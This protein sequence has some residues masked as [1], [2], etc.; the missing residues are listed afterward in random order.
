[1]KRSLMCAAIITVVL[2]SCSPVPPDF[3]KKQ[4]ITYL[5][6]D[7]T[8]ISTDKVNANVVFQEINRDSVSLDNVSVNFD[9]FLEKQKVASGKN[10][11]FNFKANDTTEFVVPVEARYLDLF[12]TTEN[13]AKA[14]IN[15][16][17][18]VKFEVMVAVT[19]YYK[20]ASFTISV[21]GEGEWPLPEVKRPKIKL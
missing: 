3:A 4:S 12:K 18:S 9:L 16:K 2:L 15:G 13:L 20:L 21:S 17:K 10:I 14:E 19:I 5:R 1:M 11:K 6:T 8:S 7:V